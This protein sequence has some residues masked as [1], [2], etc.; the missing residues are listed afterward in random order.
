MLEQNNKDNEDKLKQ[1]ARRTGVSTETAG[2]GNKGAERNW[3]YNADCRMNATNFLKETANWRNKLLR[4]WA[5]YQL[6]LKLEKQLDD[7]EKLAKWNIKA[8][9]GSMQLQGE[10]IRE[11]ALEEML[12]ATFPFDQVN[13][14]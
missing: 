7:Q 5:R 8:E 4:A 11:L 14:R 9:Q 10:V 3:M 12:R 1:A 13:G 2:T 6:R